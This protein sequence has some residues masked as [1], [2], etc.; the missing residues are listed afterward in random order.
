MGVTRELARFVVQARYAIG[1][2]RGGQIVAVSDVD[3]LIV[4]LCVV[5]G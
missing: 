5:G 2:I 4:A 3:P 1:N